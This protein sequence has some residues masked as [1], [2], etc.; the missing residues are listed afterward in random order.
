M[1][2]VGAPSSLSVE[3][4]REYGATLVGFLREKRFNLYAGSDRVTDASPS[5]VP[6]STQHI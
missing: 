2:A 6:V 3:L 5:I 4:A 1:A